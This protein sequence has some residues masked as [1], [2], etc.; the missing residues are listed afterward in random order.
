MIQPTSNEDGIG[1]S[2][3]NRE[4]ATAAAAADDDDS[5]REAGRR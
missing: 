2:G 3:L 5:S 1:Q 4:A